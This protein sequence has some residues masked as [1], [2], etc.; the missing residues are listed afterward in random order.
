MKQLSISFTLGK[1]S[2]PHGTN[3]EH[4]NRNFIAKNIDHKRTHENIT[5]VRQDVQDAYRELFQQA[6]DEYNGKQKQPCRRISDYYQ[7][8]S[9]SRREEAFYEIIVQFGDS[10]TAPCGSETAKITQQ[11][12][13]EYIRSFRE[14]NPNL[15]IFNAVMHMDEASPHLHINFIP[16]YTQERKKG[17]S[18]GVSMKAALIEQGFT[19]ESIRNNQLVAWEESERV[20]M[21]SILQKHGFYRDDKQAKYA[22][23]T[24]EEFKRTKD[25]K[26]IA[27]AL[28]S[29]RNISS[30]DMQIENV[31]RLKSKLQQAEREM[32]ALKREKLS[33][34]KSF[35]YSIP[36]KQAFVQAKLDEMQIP[37]RETENGFEAQEC[38]AEI[39]RKLEKEFKPPRSIAREKLREDIDR[40]L[41]RSD[42]VDELVKRLE[43]EGYTIKQGKYL[44]VKPK[45][46]SQYIRLKSLGEFYS[47]YALRNRINAKKKYEEQIAEKIKSESRRKSGN[48]YVLKTLQLYT[49]AFKNGALPMRKREQ[50]KPYAWTNDKE[51]DKLLLLNQKINSGMTRESLKQ[52]L[53]QQQITVSEKEKA[54]EKSKADLKIFYDL[55]EQIGIIYE[56]KESKIFSREQAERTLQHYPTINQSNYQN[57]EILI[58]NELENIEKLEEALLPEQEHLKTTSELLAMTDRVMGGTYVQSLVGEERER[59]ESDFIPNGL[60]PA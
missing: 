19:P 38:Y 7:H 60:K 32:R 37:Y 44:A 2:M 57:I 59:R 49:V 18:K 8:I 20:Y 28:R 58:Q 13:D 23:Q 51:V 39:I 52:E 9:D 34:Y 4:N 41:M 46:G 56:G 55:R 15:Y 40:S 22:H 26:K 33:P 21:E 47:E 12:L 31:Q 1:A 50:R 30:E 54:V 35:F 6:V 25:E 16:F 14:R 42:S 11:M 5:Y 10:K 45:G 3:V 53:E 27:A 17:L 36:D 29:S 43:N 24:V 48:V